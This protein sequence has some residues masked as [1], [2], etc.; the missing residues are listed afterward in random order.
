MPQE[1]KSKP[2][3]NKAHPNKWLGRLS[4]DRWSPWNPYYAIA[5]RMSHH[6]E[7][8]AKHA[9]KSLI[10]SP[11]VVGPRAAEFEIQMKAWKP[12]GGTEEG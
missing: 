12:F 11:C 8:C 7:S 1:G 3:H 5:G 6:E 2:C 4:M 10:D 9:C